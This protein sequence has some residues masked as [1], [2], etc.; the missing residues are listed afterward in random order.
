MTPSPLELILTLRCV[1]PNLL[2]AHTAVK[3]SIDEL[4]DPVEQRMPSN[5]H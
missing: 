2:T 3:L 4:I 1:V 5:T